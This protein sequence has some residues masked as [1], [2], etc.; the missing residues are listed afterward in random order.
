M[1]NADVSPSGLS[2]LNHCEKPSRAA[3]GRLRRRGRLG[4]LGHHRRRRAAVRRRRRAA[5]ASVAGRRRRPSRW[6]RN[7]RVGA[8]RAAD[9]ERQARVPRGVPALGRADRRGVLP[10]RAPVRYLLVVK[11]P[12]PYSPCH[13][14]PCVLP[15]RA[16]VRYIVVRLGRP[17]LMRHV[18]YTTR[19]TA[20]S[21]SATAQPSARPRRAGIAARR[22]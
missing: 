4:C 7:G 21:S 5:A 9:H 3:P 20:A 19:T 13:L 22:R 2:L 8:D 18:I 12:N 14:Y 17:I 1:S 6:R 15:L 10:L 11:P 16:S